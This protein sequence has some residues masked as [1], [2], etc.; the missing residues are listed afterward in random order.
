MKGWALHPSF[1]KETKEVLT[2]NGMELFTRHEDKYYVPRGF[3]QIKYVDFS[4][5]MLCEMMNPMIEPINL[6]DYQVPAVKAVIEYLDEPPKG[7][8]LFAPCGRGK[9]VMGLEI[10]RR[11]G[12]KTLVLVH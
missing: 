1:N 9:T 4:T 2:V 5:S 11:L 8:I 10:A 12:R 7:A 3:D 6:R